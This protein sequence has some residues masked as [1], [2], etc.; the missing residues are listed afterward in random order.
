MHPFS[1]KK[2]RN[3]KYEV[4]AE[5]RKTFYNLCA[6]SLNDCGSYSEMR[7][8]ANE[9]Y[10]LDIFDSYLPGDNLMKQPDLIDIL[11]DFECE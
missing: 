5:L 11:G 1:Y 2:K 9:R 4:E 7:S 10:G 6:L 3:L 8:I